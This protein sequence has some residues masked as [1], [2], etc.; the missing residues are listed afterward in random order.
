MSYSST[1]STELA[2]ALVT[3]PRITAADLYERCK[4][5]IGNT[6]LA[7]FRIELSKWISDKNDPNYIPGYESRKG[8]FGGIYKIGAKN[9]SK[10]KDPSAP[11]EIDLDPAPVIEF[12]AA[13]LKRQTRITIGDL[14]QVFDYAPLTEHQFKVQISKWLNDGRTFPEFILHK[15]P[16]GGIYLVGTEVDKWTPN[17]TSNDSEDPD[18]DESN[19]LF[20]L[21]IAPTLRIV[22]ADDRNW[23]LQK[24]SGESWL[25]KCYHNKFDGLLESAVRHIV[26]GEFKLSNTTSTQLKDIASLIR[27]MES[28]ISLQLKTAIENAASEKQHAE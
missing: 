9:E 7:Q 4:S 12:I 15:G 25:N 8:P 23:T 5:F 21:Q 1:V 28:R 24:K 22:Q 20:T 27:E 3:L 2:T 14:A 17:A 11:E 18:A 26:N 19:G 10:P 16:T 6:T 13:V